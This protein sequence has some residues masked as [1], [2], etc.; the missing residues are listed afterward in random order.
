[1]KRSILWLWFSCITCFVFSQSNTQQVTAIQYFFDTDPGVGVPGNGGII[2]VAPASSI[3]QSFPLSLPAGIGSGIH[4]VYVRA[5]DE[6]GRWSIA[7]RRMFFVQNLSLSQNINAYQYYFDNDPGV[8][9]PGNG[10]IVPVTPT[11]DVNQTVAIPLSSLSE[12]I[13]NLYIRSRLESGSWSITE[14]RMFFVQNLALSQNINAY[15][16]YFDTDP[17]VGI[18]GNGGIVPVSPTS[19]LNQTISIPLSS[20]SEGVHNLYVRTKNSSNGWSIAERR[21]FFVQRNTQLVTAMEFYFDSDPGPGNGYPIAVSATPEINAVFD[22]GVPCLFAGTHYLYIRAKDEFGRWS[23]IEKDT[24]S[25]S[26]I[27]AA[28]AV[29]PQGPLTICGNDSVTLSFTPNPG[30][31]YQWVKDGNDISGATGSSYVVTSA[32]N[33]SVK[34]IC[35][36]SNAI[37]YVVSVNTLPVTTYYADADGDGFG[38]AAVTVQ[39][40]SVPTG[41][42][43]DNTDCND[44][45]ANIHP[46]ATE[47]CNGIDDDCDGQTDEGVTITFYQDLDGDGYG[48]AAVTIQGCSAPTGYV[49]NYTDCNDAN[50]AINPGA[51]ETCGNG[52]DDNC[53]G[54]VD[55]GCCNMTVNAGTDENLYFGYALDQCVTKTASIANG[56]APLSYSWTLDRVLLPGETMTGINTASVTVCLM[57]TAQLC[58]TVTDDN[59]CTAMDCAMIF[60]EDVRC[61]SGNNQKVKICHNGTTICV[62]QNAVSA[63]LDHGDYVGPCVAT[64]ANPGNTDIKESSKTGVILY[65]NP[66]TNQIT[67]RSNDHK[68]LGTVNIYDISG[69]MIYKKLVGSSQTIIDVKNFSAGVY[70]IRSDQFQAT[71]KF[72]KQ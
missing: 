4:N 29:T 26:G 65:P 38:N 67:L 30:I 12:G 71:I 55:E 56:T 51:V 45:N 18:P 33:Y 64:V 20:L 32:G 2:S 42:V 63:H 1:M 36:S 69:K 17:G 52:I 60:A 68:T 44:S 59:N 70:F 40:C 50:N 49:S 27:V 54:Q 61:Y 47:V 57:D 23:I 66:A 7:E 6:Y 41:Y 72:V 48:N 3:D 35:G 21:M 34:A 10:V 13:H 15:Q 39:A 22:L 28:S 25:V 31:S 24:L 5:K 58:L 14:R 9:I 16:Y 53:N 43:I 19:D 11:S 37:S 8:G 46:G 62:D